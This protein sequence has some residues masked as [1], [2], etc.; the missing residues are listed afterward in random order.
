[1]MI[2]SKYFD[3]VDRCPICQSND[4]KNYFSM[5]F[6]DSKLKKFIS[7][8]YNKRISN[9]Y[10]YETDFIILHCYLC[11]F[12][13]HRHILNQELMIKLYSEWIDPATS[14]EK[15]INS[16]N[17]NNR[18]EVVKGLMR[19]F[20]KIDTNKKKIKFLD[21][22]GGW[23]DWA[24]CANVLGCNSYIFDLAE[25][26]N[27][28]NVINGVSWIDRNQHEKYKNYFDVIVVNQVLEHLPEPKKTLEKLIEMLR[29]GGIISI[30]VPNTKSNHKVLSKGPLQPL[31][32]INGFTPKALRAL[33]EKVGLVIV[34]DKTKVI[35]FEFKDLCKDLIRNIFLTIVPGRFLPIKTSIVC[36]KI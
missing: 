9:E 10:L 18:F 12:Y 36:R 19:L 20:N 22:G 26:R 33:I 17:P 5:G 4:V 6:D 35:K 24:I 1:M 23:G 2:N 32:H 14:Q 21:Y 3:V 13:W 8:Y 29:V 25:T 7:A 16:N 11:D 27:K 28:S 30:T 15:N 34:R 31:E